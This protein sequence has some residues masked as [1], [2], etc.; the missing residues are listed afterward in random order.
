MSDRLYITIWRNEERQDF[1][2]EEHEFGQQGTQN[3]ALLFVCV[4][5]AHE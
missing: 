3:V 5:F 1:G 4:C 2:D